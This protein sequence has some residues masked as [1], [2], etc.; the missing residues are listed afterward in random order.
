[1]AS[2][3]SKK[4]SCISN[5]VD[6]STNHH[7]FLTPWPLIHSLDLG[8]VSAIGATFLFDRL[9]TCVLLC[10]DILLKL[11]NNWSFNSLPWPS[12]QS[13]TFCALDIGVTLCHYT[14]RDQHSFTSFIPLAFSS[15]HYCF[16]LSI[17]GLQGYRPSF[18]VCIHSGQLY[19]FSIG[20][21]KPRHSVS[22]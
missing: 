16:I 19:Q 17:W 11:C 22:S 8:N 14:G 5:I 1:M 9:S 2:F 18:W 21:T 6:I 4:S 3:H 15:Y 12:Y 20:Q 10:T 7:V 13:A